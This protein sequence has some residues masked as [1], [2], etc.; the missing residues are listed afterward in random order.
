MTIVHNFGFHA[1]IDNALDWFKEKKKAV[2]AS[3][4]EAPPT[5]DTP[6]YSSDNV[7]RDRIS[8]LEKEIKQL[9]VHTYIW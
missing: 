1:G 5:T 6:T 3:T 4:T 8:S 2:S 7:A 9:Q